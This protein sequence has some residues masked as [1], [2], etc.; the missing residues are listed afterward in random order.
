[1]YSVIPRALMLAGLLS[2]SL[3]WPTASEAQEA[4]RPTVVED[5]GPTEVGVVTGRPEP[6][7]ATESGSRPVFQLPFR[8]DETWQAGSPHAENNSALDFGPERGS[9]ANDDVVASAAGTVQRVT[10]SG[11]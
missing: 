11:G 2:T 4:P 5:D 10:C 7:S 9:G 8:W 3:W 1:M 6:E